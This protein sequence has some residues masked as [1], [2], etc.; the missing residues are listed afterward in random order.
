MHAWST[1]QLSPIALLSPSYVLE[2]LHHLLIMS[3]TASAS[4]ILKFDLTHFEPDIVSGLEIYTDIFKRYNECKFQYHCIYF[5]FRVCSSIK[6]GS[7]LTI[8]GIWEYFSQF[9]KYLYINFY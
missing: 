9:D 5:M 7:S 8:C 3:S 2:L 1:V 4:R 6:I